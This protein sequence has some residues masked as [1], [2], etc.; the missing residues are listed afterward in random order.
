MPETLERHQRCSYSALEASQPAK[1]TQLEWSIPIC[2][3]SFFTYHSVHSLKQNS[4][5]EYLKLKSK[6]EVLQRLREIFWGKIW[7][8]WVQRSLRQLEH[9]LDKSLKQIRSTK[10]ACKRK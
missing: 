10:I 1:E 7:G 2:P 9:Q 3:L 8:I 4:Y 6:V 5:Q